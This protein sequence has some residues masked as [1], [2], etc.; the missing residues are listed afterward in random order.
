MRTKNYSFKEVFKLSTK[1]HYMLLAVIALTSFFNA[2]AGWVKNE[3][4]AL[5][6]FF[7]TTTFTTASSKVSGNNVGAPTT[8]GGYLFV[9]AGGSGG[10]GTMITN[11]TAVDDRQDTVYYEFDWNPYKL[12]GATDEAGTSAVE[13]AAFG[14][15]I[16]RGSNDSIVFGLWYERWSHIEASRYNTVAGSEPLG[17]IHL[18]N[19]STDEFN[20]VPAQVVTRTVNAVE[21]SY[22]TNTLVPFAMLDPSSAS[23]YAEKCDSINKSTNL[24]A[25][26][27]MARWYH[28]KAAIDFKNKKII[29]LDF[30]DIANPTNTVTKLDMP[31]VNTGANNVSRLEFATTRG[32]KEATTSNGNNSNYQQ[33]VDNIDIYTLREA[34]TGTVTVKYQDQ[35]GV[36][37]V[38]PRAVSFEQEVGTTFKALESDKATIIIGEDYY[39]YDETSIDSVVIAEG[40]NNIVLKFIKAT[41]ANTVVTL[42]TPASAEVHSVVSLG[43]KVETPESNP[44]TFGDVIVMVNGIAKN[45]VA[46]DVLGMGTVNLPNLLEGEENFAAVYIGDHI[47]YSTSDTARATVVM[48]PSTASVKPY[49][50]YFDLCDQPEIKDWE[51]ENGITA[52]SPRGVSVYFSTDSLPGIVVSDTIN[53]THKV[54][55]YTAGTTY[56]KIDNCYNRADFVMVPLGSGRP[57]FVKFKTPWLN[58]GSYNVYISHRVSGDAKTNWTTV[59]MDDQ[60]LYFPDEEMYGRWFK[61]WNGV[62]NRRR[63]NAIG[64]SG[65]MGMNYAGTANVS[66]S[67]T[68]TLQFNVVAENGQTFNMDML[69]FIPVDQDSLSINETAASSMA[70]NYFPMFSWLGFA[71]QPDYDV[72]TVA[73]TY[74]DFTNFAIPYQAADMT[75]WGTKYSYT[76]DSI[77]IDSRIIDG[78]PYFANYVTV[79]KAE[80]RW[81]RV[82]EG[83]SAEGSYTCELPQGEYYYETINYIDLYDGSAGYR[84]FIKSGYF[85]LPVTGTKIVNSSNIKAYTIDQTLNVKGIEAGA[86]ITVTDLTGRMIVNA[87]SN[88][89]IFTTTLPQGIYIVK[90]ISGETMTTKVSVR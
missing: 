55:Y 29:S 34:A 18:M 46:L 27:P 24:G 77:D 20:P 84:T 54:G 63:W 67:G 62:N 57:T 9:D 45:R 81:T 7:N 41:P 43:I 22:Y 4:L 78:E 71:Y 33:R 88:S 69:Q 11:M 83:Y 82:S 36:D 70:K 31:F 17:D 90:V 44:V 6:D 23:Y 3:Q 26:F 8:T 75:D 10:R 28:I 2:Q 86:Q 72:A 87:V 68:H 74:A 89:S 51:R 80:D 50:V 21:T 14:V 48:T 16:V 59:T 66:T 65:S 30:T 76:V 38:E 40:S 19:I 25:T 85:S 47:N 53:P 12:I 15:C 64:H 39:T 79:Y 37:L 35:N 60:E 42:T 73:T 52:A 49:P 1:K 5:Y 56:D 61:S 58:A 32:K 13:P